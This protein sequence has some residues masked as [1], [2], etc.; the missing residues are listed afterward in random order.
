MKKYLL[1]LLMLVFS[2]PFMLKAQQQEPEPDLPKGKLF[3]IAERPAITEY[4]SHQTLL[5]LKST[6]DL[7][8]WKIKNMREGHQS[9]IGTGNYQNNTTYSLVSPELSM[10]ALER[11][12]RINLYLDEAFSLESGHDE[13][14]VK[15]S[16][17]QGMSWDKLSIQSGLSEGKSSIINL[18]K[19]AGKDVIVALEMTA[20]ASDTYDGWELKSLEIKRDR[21]KTIISSNSNARQM[22][23]LDGDLLSLDA[24]KF[25]RFIFANV[26]VEDDGNPVA[27]LDETNFS[28]VETIKD[29]VDDVRN[30]IKD[31]TFKVY[32]PDSSEIKRPVDIVFLMDN[33]GSMSSVQNQ[34]AI[35]VESFVSSLDSKG[36][37]YRLGLCRFGQSAGQGAPIFHNN[38][39]WYDNGTDYVNMWNSVNVS[40]GSIEPSWDALYYSAQEYSFRNAA[41][42]IFILIVNEAVNNGQNINNSDIT[43]KQLVIDRL[44]NTGIQAY[45]IV[46]NSQAFEADFGSI[47]DAT[48]GESYDINQN[49]N[50]ILDDIGTQ[51][52]NTYTIRYTPTSPYFDGLKR[53]VDITVDYNSSTLLLEG[54][55]TPG[56]APIII[57]TDAT[58]DIH[59]AAQPSENPILIEVK[60]KDEIAPFTSSSTLYYRVLGASVYTELNMS[61]VS[62]GTGYS[63]WQATI[64]GPQVLDPGI[65]YYIRATDTEATTTAP[66]F[67]EGYGYPWSFAVLPNLPPQIENRT[68]VSSVK[69]GDPVHFEVEASDNTNSLSDVWIYLKTDND[70]N[71][72]FFSMQSIGND[73]FTYD[74]TAT[75]GIT[76][77]FFI[78]E[79][80]FG[81]RSFA[82]T[83]IQ[84]FVVATDIPW[85]VYTGS[86]K[87]HTINVAGFD[88]TTFTPWSI[89]ATLGGEVLLPGDYIGAFYTT[90]ECDAQGNCETVEKC[91]GFY[92]WNGKPFFG[93]FPV[94]GNDATAPAKNG[95]ADGESFTFKVFSKQNKTVYDATHIFKASSLNTTFINGGVADL[96]TLK[97]YYQHTTYPKKYLN[98]WSSNLTPVETSFDDIMADYSTIVREVFDDD[99]NRWAPGDPSNTLNTYVPGYGYEVYMYNSGETLKIEGSK[100]KL[101]QLQVNLKGQQQKTLIGCPYQSPEN[102]EAVF[103]AYVSDVYAVDKYINDG[104]GFISIET[105][106]PMF[107][108]NNWVD[109]NMV[110][111]EGY[112]VFS[113]APNSSFSFPAATGVYTSS[114]T[115]QVGQSIPQKVRST[116][117]YMHIMLPSESLALEVKEGD[118]IMA[119][120]KA[121]HKIGEAMVSVSGV[122]MVLDGL[123][124]SEGAKFDLWLRSQ[125]RELK[126]MKVAWKVGDGNYHNLKM[127]VA[128]STEIVDMV[129][130]ISVFPNPASSQFTLKY[131]SV[132]EEDI[133][134]NI[135]DLQGKNMQ[136]LEL[137]GQKDT[138]LSQKL[139][140][141][142]LKDGIYL[143]RINQGEKSQITKVIID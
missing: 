107:N 36:F 5:S 76:E 94:Y 41:Q 134:I 92:L 78:A 95:F 10:P 14:I 15:I 103:S 66:E 100:I 34:V 47:S 24:Q 85:D 108:I 124:L 68:T 27:G 3:K 72:Q 35:N 104:T 60:I 31:E 13:R 97:S 58:L 9:L 77:Y 53:E 61:Q 4:E 44:N 28:I 74:I 55:Y 117:A 89:D 123:S 50:S 23:V 105:Y 125:G 90:T 140:V 57:R 80:N 22:G 37:D 7:K 67:I 64:Q 29:S 33:S 138:L 128:T 82:G 114:R 98:L 59:K 127:A 62:S 88:P 26:T 32:A 126:G 12:D 49:F 93:S 86:T 54:E 110:P 136:R 119:Y 112:Y 69:S 19:Y 133:I 21:L 122:S 46:P 65:E 81:V 30:V 63:V 79:D 118:V 130:G 48:G 121:G 6:S 120:D 43:D 111:G 16:I 102:V 45:S 40:S 143:I 8:G 139:N 115:A 101:N 70:I 106:S 38:A 83:E 113:L 137:K 75:T 84:P 141:D 142:F 99:G 56:K 17:D 1:F 131:N 116:D 25:P 129:N 39:G 71:Y 132:S 42:K 87:R 18:S 2:L 96:D 91:G 51:V 11:S 52:G 109:K 135:T 20:D 73:L